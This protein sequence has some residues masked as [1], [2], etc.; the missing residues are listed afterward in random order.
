MENLINQFYLNFVYLLCE[1]I[2]EYNK[3]EI[4]FRNI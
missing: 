1:K 2:S 4:K 3:E